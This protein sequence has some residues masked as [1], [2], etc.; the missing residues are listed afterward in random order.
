MNAAPGRSRPPA[1]AQRQAAIHLR[2][3]SAERIHIVQQLPPA[4][5]G[6]LG[7]LRLLASRVEH[8]WIDG[9]LRSAVP[10][11]TPFQVPRTLVPVAV[12][13][14]WAA[15]EGH[16]RDTDAHAGPAP[17]IHTFDQ[18]GRLLLLLGEPGSGKT[19][20]LLE[21]AR[22][23]NARFQADPTQPVAVVFNLA[24]WAARGLP[25]AAWL[26]GELASKYFIPRKVARRWFGSARLVLLLDGLDEMGE[27]D[28]AACVQAI[29]EFLVSQAVPGLAVACRSTEYAALSLKLPLAA[30]VQLQ[31]LADPQIAAFLDGSGRSTAAVR[32]L[33]SENDDLRETARTPLMLSV[34]LSVYGERRAAA[35]NP[36]GAPPPADT[37]DWSAFLFDAYIERMI[38]RK[39]ASGASYSPER[40][41]YWLAWL[42]ANLESRRQPHLY[43]DQ[44]QPGWLPSPWQQLLYAGVSRVTMGVMFL[45]SSLLL[46]PLIIFLAGPATLNAVPG[47]PYDWIL[48]N[49]LIGARVGV[50]VALVDVLLSRVRQD[51]WRSS[52][53]L[54]WLRT[55]LYFTSFL[56]INRA[57]PGG[58]LLLLV[59]SVRG[60]GTSAETDIRPVE[61]LHVSLRNGWPGARKGFRAWFRTVAICLPFATVA[62]LA[63]DLQSGDPE[64]PGDAALLALGAGILFPLFLLFGALRNLTAT[65]S[66]TSR[67]VPNQEIRLMARNSMLGAVLYGLGTTAILAVVAGMVLVLDLLYSSKPANPVAFLKFTAGMAS[68]SGFFTVM[69]AIAWFGAFDV[70]KR[71]TLRTFLWMGGYTPRSYVRFLDA[72]VDA[73]LLYRI[74]GGYRFLHHRLQA[75]LAK[76]LPDYAQAVA[77][78]RSVRGAERGRAVAA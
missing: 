21:M 13:H 66:L 61:V 3:V 36:A 8:F 48:I 70:L 22:D 23:L 9:V 35:A 31:P 76:R 4:T 24:G 56:I 34:M 10:H 18:C 28:R 25:L 60:G 64:M 16:A 50:A 20:S 2:D 65:R 69:I 15:L 44:L 45:L 75:H 30:A 5:G 51:F 43:L 46:I 71:Y 11:E 32:L 6:E 72:A 1:A 41:R 12:E 63:T 67:T 29:R 7:S 17:L 42:A 49:C 52:R 62:L 54:V 53:H 33:L 77:D 73:G 47:T 38:A 55:L 37:A 78:A 27:A 58:A 39:R 40:L 19:I 59:M 74:G 57:Q 68:M 14:P 26:L